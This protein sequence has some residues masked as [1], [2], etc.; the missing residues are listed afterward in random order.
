VDTLHLCPSPAK[1]PA[2]LERLYLEHCPFVRS[3]LLGHG[4]PSRDVDDL[5]HDVFI[6]V[7]GRIGDLDPAHTPHPYLYVIASRVASNYRRRARNWRE[8]LPGDPPDEP[9]PEFITT[10][11]DELSAH[12]AREQLLCRV[13]RLRPKLR[14]VLIAHELEGRPMPE[15]AASLG[16]PLKTAY[17]RL[18]LARVALAR[19]AASLRAG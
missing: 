1:T 9:L 19:S 13:S 12:E 17:A 18:R 2:D 16:I 11:E 3:V 15:V 14:A 5:V 7:Q 8:E 10:A 6:I 4:V